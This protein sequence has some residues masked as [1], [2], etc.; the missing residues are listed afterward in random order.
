MNFDESFLSGTGSLFSDQLL[1]RLA[2]WFCTRLIRERTYFVSELLE[3]IGLSLR[4][5]AHRDALHLVVEL[6][7]DARAA[8]AHEHEEGSHHAVHRALLLA[9]ETGLVGLELPQ[10]VNRI[11]LLHF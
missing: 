3:R 8:R 11:R 6:A 4:E 1:I 7:V 10:S 2:S 5:V 9:V